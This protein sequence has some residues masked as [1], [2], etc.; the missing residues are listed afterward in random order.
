MLCLFL[1]LLLFYLFSQ[2]LSLIL[3]FATSLR[4]YLYFCCWSLLL[5]LFVAHQIRLSGFQVTYLWVMNIWPSILGQHDDLIF[6]V[7]ASLGALSWSLFL[8]ACINNFVLVIQGLSLPVSSLS[9]FALS[10][11][12]FDYSIY[13]TLFHNSAGA[14]D[15]TYFCN[16]NTSL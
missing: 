4:F 15:I 3:A 8:F 11:F 10:L 13:F 5:L 16:I 9:A 14:L 2:T 6:V 7:C 12:F 1:H